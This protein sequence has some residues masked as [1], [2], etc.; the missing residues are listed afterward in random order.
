MVIDKL[1]HWVLQMLLRLSV[2]ASASHSHTHMASMVSSF[3][4]VTRVHCMPSLGCARLPCAR[5]PMSDFHEDNS[6]LVSEGDLSIK[7]GNQVVAY[8]PTARPRGLR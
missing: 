5:L 2:A 4:L 8:R 6:G 3:H 1:C 7:K